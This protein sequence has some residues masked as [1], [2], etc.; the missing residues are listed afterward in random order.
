MF[1]YQGEPLENGQAPPADPTAPAVEE[2]GQRVSCP[3]CG[4]LL[5]RIKA[6]KESASAGFSVEIKCKSGGCHR[7]TELTYHEGRISVAL[8]A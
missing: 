3:S 2:K 6:V 5:C 1:F 8:L 7:L 4:R